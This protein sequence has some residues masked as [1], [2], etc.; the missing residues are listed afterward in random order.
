MASD[1][2][3]AP[4]LPTT[5]VVHFARRVEGPMSTTSASYR[6][7]WHSFSANGL[8]HGDGETLFVMGDDVVESWPTELI[9]RI[10]WFPSRPTRG[11][12][13]AEKRRKHPRAY[14]RWTE[15]EDEQL[16]K[17]H[18]DGVPVAEIAE[19]HERNEAAILARLERLELVS[20][21]EAE[22]DPDRA[23][24]PAVPASAAE[25]SWDG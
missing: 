24:D 18:S 9:R 19:R 13:L 3:Q 7:D 4:P 10:E 21:Q 2:L 1:V 20:P 23:P 25:S 8:I 17:E 15:Q 11:N 16:R 6:N 5:V 14:Q 22:P 12:W